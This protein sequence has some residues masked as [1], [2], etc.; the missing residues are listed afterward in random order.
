MLAAGLFGG[1]REIQKRAEYGI[2][3]KV[4]AS[5][6]YARAPAKVKKTKPNAYLEI[7]YSDGSNK[8]SVVYKDMNHADSFNP[9][10]VQ[11]WM[12]APSEYI[13]FKGQVP[14]NY[15]FKSDSIVDK[16]FQK[17]D[18]LVNYTNNILLEK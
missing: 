3:G 18:S 5:E 6:A 7:T 10:K 15:I 16:V 2:D 13:S 8:W 14:T 17:Y 11:Y 9:K 1:L 12:E 4:R